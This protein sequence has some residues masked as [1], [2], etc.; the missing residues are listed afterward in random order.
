MRRLV[1]SAVSLIYPIRVDDETEY[2]VRRLQIG[3]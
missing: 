3:F 1:T 2:G